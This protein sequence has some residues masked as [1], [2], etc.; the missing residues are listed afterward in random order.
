MPLAL[1]T[2][3]SRGFGAA[4]TAALVHDGWEVIVDARD[5]DALR[6]AVRRLVRP[7]A[8]TA[9]PGDVSDP[10]HR[11]ELAAAVTTRGGRLDLLVNNASALGPSPLPG[12]AVARV[13]ELADVL[14]VNAVA[15]LGLVQLLLPALRAASGTVVNVSSDAAV[16]AYPGWGVYGASKAALDHV[17]ATLAEE[18]PELRV[19][20]FDPGDMRTRMHQDAFPD[21]DVSDRPEPRTVVPLLVQLLLDRPPSGRYRATDLALTTGVLA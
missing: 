20:A 17:S 19:Y 8:V 4:L 9:L 12:L 2:G 21:E 14:A 6:G 7:A 13:E 3:A 5:G 16:E 10:L 18:H 1:V 11:Q 15:P